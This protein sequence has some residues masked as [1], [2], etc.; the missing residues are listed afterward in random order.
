MY[1]ISRR[2]RQAILRVIDAKNPNSYHEHRLSC[3]TGRKY[4]AQYELKTV[5][6]I[7][8]NE[9]MAIWKKLTARP[10]PNIN[11]DQLTALSMLTTTTTNMEFYDKL[12][13]ESAIKDFGLQDH[14]RMHKNIPIRTKLEDI[15]ASTLESLNLEYKYEAKIYIANKPRYPDFFVPVPFINYCFPLE[16]A[17]MMDLDS[18]V[19]NLQ[20][21][22]VEYNS[23]GL[24]L[25][26]N[27]LLI[28][29]SESHPADSDLIASIVCGHINFVTHRI[30]EKYNKTYNNPINI[31]T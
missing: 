11:K 6:T 20:S 3:K 31:T 29:E 24:L 25:N 7:E 30:L 21:K 9:Y 26:Q 10:I 19:S 5:K 8:L 28:T 15:V 22:I 23:N 27:L 2:N 4:H 13:A 16:A 14:P 18:Y 17:G 1:L 12:V